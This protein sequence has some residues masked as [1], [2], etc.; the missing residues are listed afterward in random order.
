MRGRSSSWSLRFTSGEFEEIVK[1][2]RREYGQDRLSQ[3]LLSPIEELQAFLGTCTT[4]QFLDCVEI[5]CLHVSTDE[6]L[7]DERKEEYIREINH[8]FREV[9]LG[10]EFLGQHVVRIDA[11]ALH[12]EVLKPTM[13]LL[14]AENN[15]AGAE[16][17][18]QT[19][20]ENYRASD[21]KGAVAEALKA[22]ESVMKSICAKRNWAHSPNDTASKLLG[23]CFVN[24]LIPT[25]LQSHFTGL[26]TVL[27]SGVPTVRNKTSGHGQGST[28]QPLEDHFVSYVLYT[29]LANIKLL[30]DCDKAL[31]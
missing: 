16:Q 19:A 1:I 29:A 2:L 30:I 15:F 28:I 8:R 25:Y 31:P 14:S 23:V 4:D 21:N 7:T 18:M 22:F 27:E 11:Q 12:A 20:F 24:N 17:E 3:F 6:D 13:A 26:R 5:Y 9:G 10:Y